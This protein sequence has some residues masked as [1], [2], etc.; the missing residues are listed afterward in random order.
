MLAWVLNT[1][2]LFEDFSIIFFF[3]G[4]F[5]V[6][7]L[8]S[9]QLTNFLWYSSNMLNIYFLW[10]W[11]KRRFYFH[12]ATHVM[13]PWSFISLTSLHH[14]LFFK[15]IRIFAIDTC[16]SAQTLYPWYYDIR[17]NEW[18]VAFKKFLLEINLVRK[19]K[20]IKWV[21]QAIEKD[22]DWKNPTT[23]L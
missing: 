1:P 10:L 3:N 20:M 5:I 12:V 18:Q 9:V 21:F 7:L 23:L 17:G 14:H 15:P 8:K 22:R 19:E 2:L 4:F 11:L 13:S 16:V 6:R